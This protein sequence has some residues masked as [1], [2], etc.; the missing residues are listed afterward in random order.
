MRWSAGDWK[1]ESPQGPV[2][3][4]WTAI[5]TKDGNTWKMVNLTYNVTMPPPAANK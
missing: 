1:N 5:E 2:R 4:F 3:C